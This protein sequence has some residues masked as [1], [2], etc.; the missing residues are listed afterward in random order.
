MKKLLFIGMLLI[1]LFGCSES[2]PLPE[3]ISQKV[4]KYLLGQ[5]IM[6]ESIFSENYTS[7]SFNGYETRE[8]LKGILHDVEDYQLTQ[9]EVYVNNAYITYEV[10]GDLNYIIDMT[11]TLEEDKWL[12]LELYV[13]PQVANVETEN[14]AEN[15]LEFDNEFIQLIANRD[16]ISAEKLL[17]DQFYFENN[18]TKFN[19]TFEDYMLNEMR[20]IMM[21]IYSC[22]FIN[23][24][25]INNQLYDEYVVNKDM[26]NEELVYIKYDENGVVDIIFRSL[27]M[28]THSKLHD[29]YRIIEEKSLEDL[30][31]TEREVLK[32][33]QS[34]SK[35]IDDHLWAQVYFEMS[36]HFKERMD[37]ETFEIYMGLLIKRY[38]YESTD[39]YFP[40]I[41][42]SAEYL[43]EVI[44]VSKGYFR[45]LNTP[46]YLDKPYKGM[47]LSKMWFLYDQDL[48]LL[49]IMTSSEQGYLESNL[50]ESVFNSGYSSI[51]ETQIMLNQVD[52]YIKALKGGDFDY[53]WAIEK[54]NSNLT[55]EEFD[56]LLG[57]EEDLIGGYTGSFAPVE[58]E[59]AIRLDKN[60]ISYQN[61]CEYSFV[62]KEALYGKIVFFFNDKLE[63]IGHH[64]SLLGEAYEN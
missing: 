3:E 6:I 62:S 38:G 22:N 24:I 37:I 21:D 4:I 63:L 19:L 33:A 30:N 47:E 13:L 45:E 35:E 56:I 2:G 7:T 17:S 46:N 11:L 34:L 26:K 14:T 51:E 18:L 60:Y 5:D 42:V 1:L 55:E 52:N 64:T 48:S 61:Q 58:E 43:E 23:K 49:G 59:K 16:F 57:I 41:K 28:M 15:I 25:E 12:L 39:T 9:N 54:V 44:T 32:K 40:N 20:F 53:L 27:A 31:L 10:Y 50:D 8:E 29:M 36:D